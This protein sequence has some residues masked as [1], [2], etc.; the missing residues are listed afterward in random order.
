AYRA[1]YRKA[2][3][4]AVAKAQRENLARPA[5]TASAAP[6]SPAAG[7]A[8]G[9]SAAALRAAAEA[10]ARAVAEANAVALGW[11]S[12]TPVGSGATSSADCTTG[13]EDGLVVISCP[14]PAAPHA[15]SAASAPDQPVGAG[16]ALSG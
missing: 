12:D 13:E 10:E 4:A 11:P 3:A 2:Y 5:T 15:L 9:P 14:L 1:A 6:S 7:A 8:G 16:A